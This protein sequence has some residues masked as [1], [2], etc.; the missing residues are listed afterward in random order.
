MAPRQL[1]SLSPEAILR[2]RLPDLRDEWLPDER[3]R[4]VRAL[5]GADGSALPVPGADAAQDH[6]YA[7]YRDEVAEYLTARGLPAMTRDGGP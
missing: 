2:L 7:G 4:K 5:L 6:G 1:L 3:L